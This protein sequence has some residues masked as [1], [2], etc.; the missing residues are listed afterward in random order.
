M[1][2]LYLILSLI[3]VVNLNHAQPVVTAD[4]FHAVGDTTLTAIYFPAPSMEP[5]S[6][7]A[8]FVWD[9]SSAPAPSYEREKIWVE[10]SDLTYHDEFPIANIGYKASFDREFYFRTST[11]SFQQIGFRRPS[12]KIEYSSGFPVLAY[13]EF[14]FGDTKIF[15][16]TASTINNLNTV[17]NTYE[18]S[19]EFTFAGFG[20]VITPMGTYENCIMTKLIRTSSR[21]SKNLNEYQFHKGRLSNVIAQY[22]HFPNG[23]E[24][25]KRIEYRIDKLSTSTNDV[26]EANVKLLSVEGNSL[27]LSVSDEI[28]ATLQIFESN[29]RQV[30]SESRN[31]RGGNNEIDISQIVHP[32]VYF[33]LVI[34]TKSGAF[35]TLE[36][37]R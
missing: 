24:P 34:D 5:P 19:D 29:G 7:G 13:D 14:S 10:A 22:S 16:Y 18:V 6:D 9:I 15:N 31:L 4:W 3:F 17:T 28:S 23:V 26:E 8:D 36:F 27:V 1:K 37:V 2:Y 25:P 11:D 35:Q 33:L 12:Y 20:T 30:L 32:N 21:S